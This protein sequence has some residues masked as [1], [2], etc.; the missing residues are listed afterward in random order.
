MGRGA[1][2]IYNIIS[3]L[4]LL[5]IAAVIAVTAYLLTSETAS[6]QSAAGLPTAA[7]IPTLTPSVTWTPTKTSLPPTF[8][9]TMTHT[10]TP[11]T[12]PS[13]TATLTPSATIT[14]TP[15]ATDTPT[16]TFTP[17]ASPTTTPSPTPTGPTPTTSATTS[18]WP[19]ASSQVVFTAN[20]ANSAGCAWQGIGGVVQNTSGEAVAN[21]GRLR[22]HV[23][24][25]DGSFDARVDVGS[26]TL[27]GAG[28]GWEVP[29]D[30]M[31]NNRR[32]YVELETSNST[33][34]AQRVEVLFPSDCSSNVALV[35]F[36]Q[37]R[38]Q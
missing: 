16:A 21:T 15:G 13:P 37:I 8:T 27:Y 18:P 23:Y 34:V 35:N 20:F 7:V 12:T 29:V 2:R 10:L 3:L 28:S 17:S 26:N 24:S 30:N 4:A 14:D 31:I 19:F 9:P 1:A 33:L 25:E 22:V 36:V 38:S 6:S 5:G 11:S 32:Y